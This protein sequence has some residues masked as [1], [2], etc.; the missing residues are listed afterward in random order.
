MKC[1]FFHSTLVF[2][3]S[4][5]NFNARKKN[6]RTFFLAEAALEQNTKQAYAR[7]MAI[8]QGVLAGAGRAG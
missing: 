2:T 3:L 1:F 6:R 8:P 5:L 4:S 7:L